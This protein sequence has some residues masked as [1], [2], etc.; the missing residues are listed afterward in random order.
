MRHPPNN[1]PLTDKILVL[2]HSDGWIEIYSE[3]WAKVCHVSLLDVPPG[4]EVA[5]E[6][7]AEVGMPPWARDIWV[8][9]HC[10]YQGQHERR[11]VRDEWDRVS[12]LLAFR[13]LG[14]LS[15]GG[16]RHERAGGR[17][18]VRRQVG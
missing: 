12:D 4:L 1:R 11:T 7:Y 17:S 13:A 6:R 18:Y 16:G 2:S 14:A 15:Q 9:D 8:A 5:A 10:A 3:A